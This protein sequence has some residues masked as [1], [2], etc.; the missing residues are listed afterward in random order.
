LDVSQRIADLQATLAAMPGAESGTYGPGVFHY[1][2]VGKTFA[3]LAT[4]KTLFIMLK[5]DPHLVEV[6][7]DQYAGVGHRTHLD[8]RYWISVDLDGDVPPEEM[9]RLCAHSYDQVR[10]KLTARQRAELAV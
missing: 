7:R 5:C 8:P 9:L 2:V 4:R 3:I 6:L 10:A 1:K